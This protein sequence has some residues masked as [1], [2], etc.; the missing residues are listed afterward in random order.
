MTYLQ[1]AAEQ[2]RVLMRA[3]G[4]NEGL[5]AQR[6][7]GD[8]TFYQTLSLARTLISIHS[9]LLALMVSLGD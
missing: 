2:T 9:N 6:G 1:A 7:R 4:L 5:G 8:G 3:S